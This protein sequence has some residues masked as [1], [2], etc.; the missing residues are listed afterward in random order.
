[1]GDQSSQTNYNQPCIYSTDIGFPRIDMECDWEFKLYK[2]FFKAWRALYTTSF[3]MYMLGLWSA[4]VVE[5]LFWTYCA[6]LMTHGPPCPH[7]DPPRPQRE[8]HSR[9]YLPH[10]LNACV[11]LS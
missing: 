10:L 11:A 2:Q 7:V 6:H 9:G 8:G 1:M 5:R 3:D 4:F